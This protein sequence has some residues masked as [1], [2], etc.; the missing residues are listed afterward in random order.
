MS[1]ESQLLT[2]LASNGPWALVAGF[3]LWQIMKAWT[4]DRQQVTELLR[5]FKA[6]IDELTH[7]VKAWGGDIDSEIRRERERR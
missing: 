5:E 2:G 3:L 1:G 7:A 6:S 4:A